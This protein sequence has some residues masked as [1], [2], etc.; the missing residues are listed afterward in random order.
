VAPQDCQADNTIDVVAGPTV[1]TVMACGHDGQAY[2]AQTV[3]LNEHTYPK[4][5]CRHARLATAP[6]T[7]MEGR[8]PQPT[9]VVKAG[10]WDP[11]FV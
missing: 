2:V 1:T 7:R 5:L 8:R 11:R 6:L 4:M 9:Q 3:L 10:Y